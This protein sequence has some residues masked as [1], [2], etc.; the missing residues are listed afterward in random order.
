MRVPYAVLLTSLIVLVPSHRA[1]GQTHSQPAT[2]DASVPPMRALIERYNADHDTI[3]SVYTDPYSPSTRER[4]AAFYK[5]NRAAL[6]EINFST[7]DREGQADYL[8]FA[9]LLTQQGHQLALD[10]RQWNE[11]AP[12]LPFASTIFSLEDAKRRMERPDPQKSAATIDELTKA[13]AASRKELD[14]KIKDASAPERI[15]A[16][17]AAGDL[18]QLS[19]QLRK[20][21]DFS[22][23]YD[24]TFTWWVAQP[25]KQAAAALKDD[26]TFLR[27]KLA[28]IAPD[29]KAT[30]I[31]TPIGRDAL[32]KQLDDAMIPYTPE[33]LIAMAKDQLAW[34]QSEVIKASRE[35]GYGDDWHKAMEAVKN[36]YVEAG[37]QPEL[38]RT[39]ALEGEKFAEDHDL[40]TIPPLA[41]ETWRMEMMSPERQLVNPFFLGG[42][43]IIVSYP[44]DTMT[45]DQR[46][47]SMR[48]NNP[49]F[50]RATVF[51][52]L[53]PGHWLQ[54]FMTAR[55][56]PYRQVFGSGFWIEGN[57]FYWELLFW[58]LG[59]DATPQQRIGALF[60]RMHR[61]ARIIFSLSF[62]LGLMTPQQ[63]IDFLVSEVGHERDNATAEVRR[64]V[65]GDYDP[66]YQCAYMLGALEFRAL[67]HEL[68][69]S[70]KMT[71]RQYNDAILRENM[72]PIPIL[73]AL[74]TGEKLTPGWRP[75]WKFLAETNLAPGK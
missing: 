34:C 3:A 45:Y 26:S 11:V 56:R 65:N 28:G 23:G 67:R 31:G 48:G 27:E 30:V 68:V 72:M 21:F 10:Q 73:R 59:F 29:D 36:T 25:Y 22:N 4:W 9:N 44:T 66:L 6:D 50:S 62:H 63:A 58:D 12:L 61:C 75:Q 40:V 2:L 17:R 20:W 42:D 70:G 39:L 35:L 33:E 13:V 71:N 53:I 7:L 57:A 69:D 37:K 5:D 47:M 43:T 14:A 16:W 15:A 46:M 52:E 8:L 32:L 49:Y 64:S 60:W 38:I 51:H 41:K 74:L 19:E 55:Y 18:D 54:E 24:P 1:H